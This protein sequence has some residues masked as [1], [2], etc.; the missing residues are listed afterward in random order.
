VSAR[1]SDTARLTSLITD[2]DTTVV[3]ATEQGR[4]RQYAKA[5]TT[6]EDALATMTEIEALRRRLIATS[7][8][9]ILDE[10]IERTK[11]YDVALRNV[12]LALK[13]SKGKVTVEVQSARR[14]ERLAFDQLPPDRRTILVIISEVTRN[15]LTQAVLAIEDAHS[16]LDEA[17]AAVG[18]PPSPEPAS[19]E[20]ASPEPT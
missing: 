2:H 16:R 20:P 3:T 5:A 8:H 15:G 11:D 10:W 9:T 18:A 17:L 7:E 13:A 4:N 14:E 12:Y 19:P 1:A 6:L